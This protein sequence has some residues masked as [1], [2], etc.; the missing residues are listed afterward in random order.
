MTRWPAP[1]RCKKRLSQGI[2]AHRAAAIQRKLTNHTLAVAKSLLDKRLIDIK[3]AVEGIG[4]KKISL[5]AKASGISQAGCQGK[6]SLGL[7]M[8]RQLVL[9][10][11]E[12]ASNSQKLRDILFIGTDVPDLSEHDI[13]Y[14]IDYL[15]RDEIVIG[16]AKDG[17]YW[18]IGFSRNILRSIISWPFSG[19]QWGSNSVFQETIKKANMEGIKYKLINKKSDLDRLSDLEL[20]Y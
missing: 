17:G 12:K 5:W 15:A 14:A 19:I 6:G 9:A 7:K 18:L 10:Q 1:N 3:L 8:K 16:P 13:T 4:S 2:G 20:W 11:R